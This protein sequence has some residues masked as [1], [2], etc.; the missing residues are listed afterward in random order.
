MSIENFK[1]PVIKPSFNHLLGNQF[2][3]GRTAFGTVSRLGE[4][5]GYNRLVKRGGRN[6]QQMMNPEQLELMK[7]IT[8]ARPRYANV[9]AHYNKPM[10][11]APGVVR[12][13]YLVSRS[14]HYN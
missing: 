5:R 7:R 8:T 11:T 1:R 4:E 9:M 3:T 6:N 2:K 14:P 12:Q 10:N 13:Q